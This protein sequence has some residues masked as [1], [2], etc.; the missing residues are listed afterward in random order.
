VIDF[1][2]WR[3]SEE[4][5]KGGSDEGSCIASMRDLRFRI[6]EARVDKEEDKTSWESYD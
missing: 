1:E 4:W 3:D 6:S 2:W 5:D